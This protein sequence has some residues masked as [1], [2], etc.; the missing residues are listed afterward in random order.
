MTLTVSPSGTRLERDG[1]FVPLIVDTIWAA[2]CDVAEDD[3]RVYL[4]LRR[5]QGFTAIIATVLPI[6]HDRTEGRVS[7]Y[8]YVRRTDGTFDWAQP[9]ES[10]FATARRFVEIAR[11]EY[12]LEVIL[13]VTWTNYL[14]GTWG[15]R[16]EPD[17]VMPLEVLLAH[18][19]RVA[20]TFGPL[21][22]IWAVG[23]DDGYDSPEANRRYH[24]I[25]DLLRERTPQLLI[26]T[27]AAPEP[28]TPDD[29]LD[30]FDLHLYQSGH[31]VDLQASAWEQAIALSSRGPRRPVIN[32]EPPYEW[33][34]MINGSGR[35]APADIR[36]AGWAG[37]LSGAGAGIGYA[38]HGV[39]MWATTTG[40]FLQ[41]PSLEPATWV[42]AM[43]FP[44][45]R[46]VAL[47]AHLIAQHRLDRL[48]AAQ[49]LLPDVPDPRFRA[50][51]SPDGDLLAFYLPYD[52]PLLVAENLAGH[53]ITA[54]D[55]AARAPFVPESQPVDGGTLLRATGVGADALVIVTE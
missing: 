18:V 28:H 2:F 6:V 52:R 9:D 44:G 22:P 24:A 25:I 36:A 20:E 39:W 30:R 8:P 46:D 35:W 12:G 42:E 32:V 14:P 4:R 27:H 21:E 17:V 23:G 29:L 16:L 43:T 47:L 54:W 31:N 49:Q 45:V 41:A 50:G 5:R 10:Y 34:G 11:R 19:E 40:R 7:R 38:A 15:S 3:W 13:V 55:L 48:V 33:H 37:V 26:T 1:R 53:A 51:A